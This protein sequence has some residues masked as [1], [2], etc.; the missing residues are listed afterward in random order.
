MD[1]FSEGFWV[2][3]SIASAFALMCLLVRYGL[4][5]KEEIE[6]EY[7]EFLRSHKK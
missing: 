4:D 5:H 1:Q 3:M 6:Q 2:I 7:R